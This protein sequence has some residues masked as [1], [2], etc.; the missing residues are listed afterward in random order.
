MDQQRCPV[1]AFDH[2]SAEH[3]RHPVG[4]YRAVREIGPV[5][6]TAAHGGY[7]V[8]TDYA[9]VFT[10]AR[11]EDV[12][13]SARGPHGG[14]GLA[15]VIP[16]V[17]VH[18]HIPVELDPPRSREYRKILNPVTSPA[19]IEPML[20]RIRAWTT[21][22][23]D[24]VIE[25]G[26]CDLAA[27]IGVPAVITLDWLGLSTKD[28]R[29]YSAA[30]HAVL[31]DRP[32]SPAHTHAVAVDIPWMT[33]QVRVAIAARRVEPKDDIISWIVGASVN[34]EPISDDDAYSMVE[35]L[36]SGGVGT[37]ASLVSQALVWLCRNPSVC[38]RLRARPALLDKAVEE[39]VRYFAPT[40]ALARTVTRDTELSG[41]P[42]YKGDRVLLAWASANRDPKQFDDPDTLNI[43]RWPNRHTG[44]GIG[45]HRC[46]GSHLGRAMARELIRQVITRMPDYQVDD[47]ALE[48]YPSQ[49]VN[50]G[51]QRIPT[52]FTPG[53]RLGANP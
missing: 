29:R 41:C 4:A 14:D 1:V 23:I 2:T 40:Q 31:A 38:D 21:W 42:L 52:R 20:P 39:F 15:T 51:W 18:L 30:L 12:F 13:S 46:A 24:Q 7:F 45:V 48:A 32:G 33:E 49:G 35:L 37:T 8:A 11:T 10:A 16:K 43:E 26:E 17:P 6:R 25:S 3:S 36:I 9:S 50:S 47:G 44:F 22:F 28:W 5:V 53:P 27:V 34:G 19:A